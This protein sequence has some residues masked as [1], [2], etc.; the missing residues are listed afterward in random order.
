M[1]GVC[2]KHGGQD[3]ERKAAQ[4][5]LW[6]NVLQLLWLSAIIYKLSFSEAAK[7]KQGG[8]STNGK[9]WILRQGSCLRHPGF[10][11]SQTFQPYLEA[12]REARQGDR[13][14]KSQ[15]CLC[16]HPLP[17][18]RQ[19]HSRCVI[20]YYPKQ[21]RLTAGFFRCPKKL[22]RQLKWPQK[23]RQIILKELVQVFYHTCLTNGVQFKMQNTVFLFGDLS[24][25]K[26]E[27]GN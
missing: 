21:A 25:Y 5:I 3:K 16:L 20:L 14:R 22:P 7:H 10:P 8:A 1:H 15:A 17:A 13:G 2:V 9:V 12:Q 27:L 4:F 23:V 19:G 24:H 11:F 18:Q 26:S 6:K